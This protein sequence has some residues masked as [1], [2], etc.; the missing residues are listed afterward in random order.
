MILGL[1]VAMILF[2]LFVSQF[3]LAGIGRAYPSI[4][5]WISFTDSGVCAFKNDYNSG[6]IYPVEVGMQRK[7]VEKVFKL[8]EPEFRNLRGV[9]YHYNGKQEYTNDIEVFSARKNGLRIQYVIKY[10]E[11]KVIGV[12]LISRAFSL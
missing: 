9:V 11:D 5:G 6:V 1:F 4:V 12:Q 3:Y 7:V 10:K 8:R 2:A